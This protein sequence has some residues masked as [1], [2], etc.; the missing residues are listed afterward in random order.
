MLVWSPDINI[1]IYSRRLPDHAPQRQG[2]RVAPNCTLP[3]DSSTSGSVTYSSSIYLRWQFLVE[4][5][6]LHSALHPHRCCFWERSMPRLSLVRADA[7]YSVQTRR[8]TQVSRISRSH[9]ASSSMQRI[10]TASCQ[11]CNL[12]CLN[13]LL[14]RIWYASCS[15]NRGNS[16]FANSEYAFR[17]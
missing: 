1:C 17:K 7:A 15:R 2:H 12:S 3:R 13:P 11:L 16:R 8:A 4:V 6:A 14:I 5:Y 9:A 10:L